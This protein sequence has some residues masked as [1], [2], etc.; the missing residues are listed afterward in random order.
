MKRFGTLALSALRAGAL[1][2]SFIAA[3]QAAPAG[4]EE[5]APSKP[6]GTISIKQVQIAFIGSGSVGGGTLNYHGREYG[7]SLGGL[8]VGGFGAS[9]LEATGEVYNLEKISDFAGVYGEVRTGWAIGD[10]GKGKIWLRN[11]NGVLISISGKRQGLQLG[12]GADGV[13]IQ[14]D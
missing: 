12:L 1:A 2:F 4:A 11:P 3:L 8:G 10:H 14:L 13:V 9:K 5:S 6:S 7:F